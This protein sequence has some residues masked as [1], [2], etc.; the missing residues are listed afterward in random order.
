MPICS[1]IVTVAGLYHR[2]GIGV[3]LDAFVGSDNHEQLRA[4]VI[5]AEIQ[6]AAVEL[7][8]EWNINGDKFR[9]QISDEIKSALPELRAVISKVRALAGVGNY[10]FFGDFL[11]SCQV[12]DP[13]GPM[14]L[15]A[16]FQGRNLLDADAN[17][18]SP[19]PVAKAFAAVQK[20]QVAQRGHRA[21]V[22][23]HE[24]PAP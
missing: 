23:L 2:K 12:F 21:Y 6:A 5:D 16:G 18:K 9:S 13:V 14:R 8:R 10:S 1:N 3:L 19:H 20:A 24:R 22:P 7:N 15:L 11:G 17:E 4:P